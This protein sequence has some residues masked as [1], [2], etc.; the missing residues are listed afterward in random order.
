MC[1]KAL[2]EGYC[3]GKPLRIFPYCILC[4]HR[5]WSAYQPMHLA[6]SSSKTPCL[7]HAPPTALIASGA[8]VISIAPATSD[9]QFCSLSF[10]A[11]LLCSLSRFRSSIATVTL[12]TWPTYCTFLTLP[13]SS[14]SSMFL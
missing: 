14:A 2:R 7:H 13:R 11:K 6:S 1:Q 12:P 3:L 9:G 10:P 4:T 5:G 8:L